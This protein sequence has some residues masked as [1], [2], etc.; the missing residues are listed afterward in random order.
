M[1]VVSRLIRFLRNLSISQRLI[2]RELLSQKM[3]LG[4]QLSRQVCGL[5]EIE[6]FQDVEFKVFSQFG[7]DELFNT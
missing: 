1:N 7:D 5:T 4:K 2:Q 3:L 6:S